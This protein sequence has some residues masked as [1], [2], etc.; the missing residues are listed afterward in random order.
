M[1]CIEREAE[2]S[3]SAAPPLDWKILW[4][5]LSW[6]QVTHYFVT[7]FFA[8]FDQIPLPIC[9]Q[10]DCWLDQ[11]QIGNLFWIILVFIFYNQQ[12]VCLWCFSSYYIPIKYYIK[13]TPCNNNKQT[14]WTYNS[15]L[16]LK[17]SRMMILHS[18]WMIVKLG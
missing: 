16:D 15:L 6:V 10:D 13:T 18:W 7:L 12:P 8:A 11:N 1:S 14:Q 4:T 3:L 9:M 5:S 2:Q 17:R